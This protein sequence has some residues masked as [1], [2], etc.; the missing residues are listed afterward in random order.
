MNLDV[1]ACQRQ[2]FSTDT[3]TQISNIIDTRFAKPVG[4][5]RGDVQSRS[6]LEPGLGEQ[7]RDRRAL[8]VVAAV[9][10]F[11][12]GRLK[13]ERHDEASILKSFDGA[14]KGQVTEF[15]RKLPFRLL[16]TATA[17]PMTQQ[18]QAVSVP[19]VTNQQGTLTQSHVED[20]PLRT[21]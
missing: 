21:N 20:W 1:K 6:L 14:I 11:N 8:L 12:R 16:C 4:V 19:P 10:W 17:A 18:V 3:A 5:K 7:V 13:G 2:R 9:V 15:M